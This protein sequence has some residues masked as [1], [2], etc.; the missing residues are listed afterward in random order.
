[1]QTYLVQYPNKF[2][3]YIFA[4]DFSRKL[5]IL[6]RIYTYSGTPYGMILFKQFDFINSYYSQVILNECGMVLLSTA[7][8][9]V[10]FTLSINQPWVSAARLRI[11]ILQLSSKV[12]MILN[13]YTVL[14]YGFEVYCLHLKR[15]HTWVCTLHMYLTLLRNIAAS[16]NRYLI[17][18]VSYVFC[19]LAYVFK[20][21]TKCSY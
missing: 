20:W 10:L 16:C 13:T 15:W 1:M 12:D 6:L 9:Y 5:H 2:G 19:L 21:L 4:F 3:M 11:Q 14:L 7:H 8:S 17:L 18:F